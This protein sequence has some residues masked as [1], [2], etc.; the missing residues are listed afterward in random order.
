MFGCQHIENQYGWQ[1][2]EKE[3]QA[4]EKHV[5]ERGFLSCGESMKVVDYACQDLELLW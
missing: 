5:G 1:K 2:G 4:A 3:Q